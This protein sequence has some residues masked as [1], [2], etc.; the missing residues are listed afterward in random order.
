MNMYGTRMKQIEERGPRLDRQFIGWPGN[1]WT[2]E[3]MAKAIRQH[4]QQRVFLRSLLA[5]PEDGE[6]KTEDGG[7]R[8]EDGGQKGEGRDQKT[9][10]RSQSPGNNIVTLDYAPH[11]AQMQIHRARDKRFRMVCTG[12]RFGKTLCLAAELLDRGG[13]EKGG[14][15]GWVA[16][17]YNVAERGI[18]A[19]RKFGFGFV[20]ESGR[21]PCRVEF[22]GCD[23]FP[24]TRI[25]FLSAD[26]PD[27][28]RGFGFQGLVIDEAA[29][30]PHDVWQYVLRPTISQTLGW[31]MLVSTPAGR[32]W[33]YDLFTRGMDPLETNYASFTFPSNASPFF[34]AQEWEEARRVYG[35]RAFRQEYMAEFMEDSA[36]VFKGI[37]AC[38]FNPDIEVRGQRPEVSGN[39][40]I[41]C[42]V[43]KHKDWTVL[44]AMDAETGRCFAMD[45][46][47]QLDW[48]IQKER[49]VGFAR[50]WHGRV[51]MDATGVGDPIY[52]DLKRVLPDIEPCLLTVG[53]KMELI[54]RLR[55]AVELR[56]VSWPGTAS[57]RSG[58]Q[59]VGQS[60]G[61]ALVLPDRRTAGLSDGGNWGILTDEMKR[62]EF[63]IGETGRISYGAPSGYHDDCVIALA[64]AN[65]RKWEGEQCGHMFAIPGGP[66]RRLR[67]QERCVEY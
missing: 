36:G 21:T 14:D 58:S 52:D 54:E 8:S 15:Y 27:N 59:T 67:G 33:F 5:M 4:P 42:D 18:E 11:A 22:Q 17:T 26:N 41:G 30:I 61:G 35:E 29:T 12:R 28:M 66:R 56:K 62:Y 50:Q 49:I 16:P 3:Q 46:F 55:M 60:G 6:R 39:V 13:C 65:H 64:L 31:A 53:K 1:P 24:R 51:I 34:P 40:V 32:N 57:S 9:E 47:N 48:P 25:W 63:E 10:V 44:I 2:P 37:D 7:Q 45:R 43:A 19:F 38:L 20:Q 23:G